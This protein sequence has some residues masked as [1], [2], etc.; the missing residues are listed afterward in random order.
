MAQPSRRLFRPASAVLGP[1]RQEAYAIDFH[2]YARAPPFKEE[3]LPSGTSMI[4]EGG[5][6]PGIYP[7]LSGRQKPAS[8]HV[9]IGPSSSKL[10]YRDPK[11]ALS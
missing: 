10:N 7:D 11:S 8:L 2:T 3:E 5:L 4:F 9:T 1:C 6:L